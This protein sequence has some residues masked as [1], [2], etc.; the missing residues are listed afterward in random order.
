MRIGNDDTFLLMEAA[1]LEGGYSAL[2]VEAVASA[3]G[4]KFTAAHDRLMMDSDEA[5]VQRFV[6]FAD[7]KREQFETPF[8]EGGWLRFQRDSHGAIIVRYRVGGWKA[9]A[10]MEGEVLV[11][12]EFANSFCREFGALLRSQ[13]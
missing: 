13:R 6:E 8:T 5:T 9:A 3:S 4:R 1:P 10:A 12:G 2:R 11:D 7:L